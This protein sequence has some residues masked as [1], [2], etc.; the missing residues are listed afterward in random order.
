MDNCSKIKY[1]QVLDK[2]YEVVKISF[3]DFAVEARQT[4]LSIDDLPANEVFNITDMMDFKIRLR[5]CKGEIVN[6]ADWKKKNNT[7]DKVEKI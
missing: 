1:I 6:L 7:S 2:I 4:D 3:F 5:N